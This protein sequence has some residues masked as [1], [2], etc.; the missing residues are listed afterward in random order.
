MIDFE[1]V[2]DKTGVYIFKNS[3]GKIIYIGKANSLKQRVK[4]YFTGNQDTRPQIEFIKRET[5]KI[6]FSITESEQQA[7]ILEYNL[8]S[9][10]KPKYNVKLKDSSKYPYIML[11]KEEY[12]R[13]S[14]TYAA[15]KEGLF[16]GPFT[17]GLYV[18]TLV[19]NINKIYKLRTCKKKLPKKACIEHQMGNCAGVCEFGEEQA[20]YPEKMQKI[21]RILNGGTREILKELEEEMKK[22]ADSEDFESA[23]LI[24]DTISFI[25]RE[26]RRGKKTGL[27][28]KNADIF[29]MARE[30]SSGA[31]S[32]LKLRNGTVHEIITKRFSANPLLDDE[33]VAIEILSEYYMTT[34]DFDFKVIFVEGASVE[35]VKKDVM[36]ER[37][38]E[39]KEVGK[40]SYEYGLYETAL[41]NAK[42]ELYFSINKR[43]VS[44]AVL[45]LREDLHLKRIPEYIVG[46][47][48]SHVNGEW[49]SGA[50]VAFKDGKPYKSLYR[51]YNLEEIGNND[52]LALSRML[53]RYLEKHPVDMIIIDGGLG[54]LS[55]CMKIV[56]ETGRDLDVFALAK[57]FDI[58]YD[59]EGR[60]IMLNGRT[61]GATLIK[62]IR[63]EAHRFA[64]K[65]R[66]IKM[67]KMKNGR[68]RKNIAED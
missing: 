60:E 24:R 59:S 56:K 61:S 44:K 19:E 46:I 68:E 53:F 21:R 58:L 31:F 47:D 50:V 7:L 5:K 17:S 32:V 40:K 8:I 1:A 26:M 4:Q 49:T 18:K 39:V 67:E 66:K 16:F 3:E 20:V 13:L 30:K 34:T 41:E 42:N 9:A 48:I 35:D 63:D 2:P 57:R 65:L 36:R 23:A 29:A 54:Q 10:N 6:E 55:S 27:K 22:N 28:G 38:I 51:Y 15:E 11:S 62:S 45:Q 33:T 14:Y 64:N 25:K 12:P 52:Y 43:F 37:D